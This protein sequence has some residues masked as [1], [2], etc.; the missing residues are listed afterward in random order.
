MKRVYALML[1]LVMTLALTACGGSDSEEVSHKTVENETLVITGKDYNDAGEVEDYTAE[2]QYTGQVLDGIPDGTGTFTC[3]N[4]EGVTWSYS[5]EFKNGQFH[6]KGETVWDTGWRECG[7]YTEGLFTPNT[8]ELFDSI[9]EV[10]DPAY[11]IS[12]AN[13]AFMENNL[14]LFPVETEDAKASMDTLIQADLTYPMMTK[15]LDG[16]EGKLYHCASAQATQVFQDVVFG[17]TITSIICMDSDYNFYYI[18]Y[19][20]T[21]PD[22]YDGTPIE[23]VG[24][25]VSASG[26]S[27]VGGGTTNVIVLIA[28]SVTTI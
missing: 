9:S 22:V 14:E 15:T 18:C 25:P 12:E 21:L 8:F 6:G 23:F 5:G 28:C 11:S 17:H 2:G 24:L 10:G 1:S 4:D 20:G 16:L 7:T 13:Q 3:Q 19:D 26:F 27:N